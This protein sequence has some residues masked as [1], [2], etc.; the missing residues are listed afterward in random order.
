MK[1]TNNVNFNN[2]MKSYK[3][4]V[5]KTAKAS[6]IKNIQDKIEISDAAREVQV[7]TKAFREL[8]E[9]RRELV[10]HLKMAVDNGSY[11]PSAED[12]AAKMVALQLK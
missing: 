4:P 2:I 5:E 7:A 3:K 12:V 1:I 11:K 10:D 9:V 6:G 8:P